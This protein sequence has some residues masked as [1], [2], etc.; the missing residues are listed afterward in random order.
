MIY[1]I[2]S[3]YKGSTP[4]QVQKHIEYAKEL[5]REVL[6]HGYCA[7]TPH[8]YITNCLNDSDQHERW[9][10][11]RAGIELLGKC[12]A[13]VVGQ[14]YGISEGMK[15]EIKRAKEWNIPIF[16]RD[17]KGEADGS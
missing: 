15:E 6:L 11:R 2:C 1:Y 3:P 13:V 12:D 4:E 17:K 7:V 5:T 16:Y 9:I 14:L 8:L 10:G